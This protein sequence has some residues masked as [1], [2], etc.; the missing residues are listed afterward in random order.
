MKLIKEINLTQ[1]KKRNISDENA[2]AAIKTIIE[3]IGENP[4]REGLL[5]TPKRVIKAFKEYFHGYSQI[6]ANF[7]S[8]TFTEIEGYDD[9]AL[10][11]NHKS[12]F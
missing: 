10:S 11:L 4:N 6:P 1:V 7:L 3:W 12:F 5:S 9:I 8:K 2:E